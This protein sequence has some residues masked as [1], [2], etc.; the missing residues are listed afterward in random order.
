MVSYTG[1]EYTQILQGRSRDEVLRI[2]ISDIRNCTAVIEGHVELILAATDRDECDS[3][4][5]EDAKGVRT[6][7]QDIVAI[8]SAVT[9]YLVTETD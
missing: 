3:D 5:A 8:L 6:C 2:L 7:A 4:V 9:D 1:A